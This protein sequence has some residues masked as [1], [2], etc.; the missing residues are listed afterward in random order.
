MI[1]CII[2]DYTTTNIL[3]INDYLMIE[4]INYE[5]FHQHKLIMLIV[6][7]Q[8]RSLSLSGTEKNTSPNVPYVNYMEFFLSLCFNQEI[9]QADPDQEL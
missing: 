1:L 9:L 7:R 5:L 4:D 6:Y 8:E 2:Y 3:I